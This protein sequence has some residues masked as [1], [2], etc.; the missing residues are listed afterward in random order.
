MS[1]SQYTVQEGRQINKPKFRRLI[2]N[3]YD[4][5]RNRIE[6]L[7]GNTWEHRIRS[8][9]T[10]VQ[11]YEEDFTVG[12]HWVFSIMRTVEQLHFCYC[13]YRMKNGHSAVIAVRSQK[14]ML[15]RLAY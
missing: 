15:T 13:T 3:N 11:E 2:K 5:R 1:I 8:Y 4:V 6:E 9:R 14:E 12:C 7:D 10:Y